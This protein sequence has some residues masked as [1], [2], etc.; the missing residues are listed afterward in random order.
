MVG[1]PH[2]PLRGAT[3]LERRFA[4]WLDAVKAA[5]PTAVEWRF[6]P[7]TLVLS[8]EGRGLRY[9]PDFSVRVGP[10]LELIEVKPRRRDNPAEPLWLG[11]SRTKVMA[12][13]EW[14][15]WAPW[16]LVLVLPNADGTWERRVL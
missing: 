8:R 4:A 1:R 2:D 5:E 15:R 12:A 6:Q 9:T 11:D 14:G 3:K 10:S 7:L 16:S 13:A